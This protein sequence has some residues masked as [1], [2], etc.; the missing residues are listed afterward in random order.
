M[1]LLPAATLGII[2]S[3]A[4][5]G[6]VLMVTPEL[7]LLKTLKSRALTQ[8]LWVSPSCSEPLSPELSPRAAN[9]R[10]W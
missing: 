4:A 10:P 3:G 6:G 2:V 5:W 1:G 9:C 7:D 8:R